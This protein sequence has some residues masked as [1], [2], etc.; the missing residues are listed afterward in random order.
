MAHIR[1]SPEG[2]RGLG[3]MFGLAALALAPVSAQT[4]PAK[5]AAVKPAAGSKS[6]KAP[7]T[8]WG[9]PDLQGTYSNAFEGGTPLERPQQ[10]EGR[11]IEDVK[12][13]ELLEVKKAAHERALIGVGGGLHAPDFFWQ[14]YYE[15]E[16]GAQ[17]WLVVDPPDGKIPT[18]TPEGRQRAA[19]RAEARRISGRGTADSYEDRSCTTAVSRAVFPAR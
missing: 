16:K 7:R 17:A 4:T 3:V 2:P 10:F 19:D 15:L 14:T 11:R 18:V 12:G 13:D 6:Y 1:R 5:T 8:P 9:D